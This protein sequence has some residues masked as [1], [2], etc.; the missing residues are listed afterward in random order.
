[1]EWN[2]ENIRVLRLR[3]GMTQHELGGYLGYGQPQVR[4]S[5]L[6][7]GVR[8]PNGAAQRLLDML[9]QQ[10]PAEDASE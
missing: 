1:M 9:E 10:A 8:R 5:E 7:R 6:E 3:L 4:V 2:P